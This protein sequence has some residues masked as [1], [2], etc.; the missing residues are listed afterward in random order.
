MDWLFAVHC[1][2]QI[3]GA[4]TM[5]IL[6]KSTLHYI[7]PLCF[8]LPLVGIFSYIYHI[9]AHTFTLVEISG[10]WCD[11]QFIAGK[12]VGNVSHP[13]QVWLLWLYERCGWDSWAT[14]LHTQWFYWPSFLH[15][16]LCTHTGYVHK[17]KQA[18][19]FCQYMQPFRD[20]VA[21]TMSWPVQLVTF[22]TQIQL[23]LPGW[24][25]PRYVNSCQ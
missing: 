25:T 13:G 8:L 15:L 20:S 5:Y 17:K 1:S 11:N 7:R 9:H 21:W 23:D 19:W 3:S 2:S 14:C 10:W 6:D 16:S 18:S 22:Q 12:G 24:S 4:C